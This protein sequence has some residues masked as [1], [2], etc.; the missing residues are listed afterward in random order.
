MD[1]LLV[2][3]RS[4]QPFYVLTETDM[5]KGETRGLTGYSST[6]SDTYGPGYLWWS[7]R[8]PTDF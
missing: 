6:F 5:E 8:G 1:G 3:V 2:I 7:D 4:Q